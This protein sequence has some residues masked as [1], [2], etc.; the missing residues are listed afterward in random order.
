[1]IM[2]PN[3][4]RCDGRY[5][6]VGTNT[7]YIRVVRMPYEYEDNPEHHRNVWLTSQQKLLRKLKGRR[8][9][10]EEV[11]FRPPSFT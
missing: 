11:S 6:V 2:L 10:K 1:M 5:L 4:G 9:A 8:L 3:F 7:G